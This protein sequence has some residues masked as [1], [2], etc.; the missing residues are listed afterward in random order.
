MPLCKEQILV[1]QCHADL[2]TESSDMLQSSLES[3]NMR[4]CASLEASDG[5]LHIC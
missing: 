1:R 2:P 3:M 4:S 5:A